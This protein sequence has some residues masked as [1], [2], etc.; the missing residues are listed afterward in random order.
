MFHV[1]VVTTGNAAAAGMHCRVLTS[2]QDLPN[3]DGLDAQ[4]GPGRGV[5]TH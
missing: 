4:P 1:L 5:E 3:Y 2:D